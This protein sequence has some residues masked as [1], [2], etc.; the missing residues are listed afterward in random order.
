MIAA[1][2]PPKPVYYTAKKLATIFACTPAK[3]DMMIRGGEIE[4]IDF[5]T[6]PGQQRPRYLVT[7]AALDEFL[8]RRKT[9][10]RQ[11]GMKL[12][13]AAEPAPSFVPKK[14]QLAAAGN[15]ICGS[16]GQ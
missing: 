7:Q 2:S 13:P 3:I 8:E 1:A 5:G 16:R 11:A 14:R 4:A 6:K 10:H 15:E 12:E 9:K